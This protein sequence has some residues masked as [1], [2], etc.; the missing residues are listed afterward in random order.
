MTGI[1]EL[2]PVVVDDDSV[3]TVPDRS[4][5][6]SYR[7]DRV[8]DVKHAGSRSR[9]LTGIA[10]LNPMVTLWLTTRL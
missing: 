4:P 1:A 3:L 9:T 5:G 6:P 10:E 8:H 2:N 7:P